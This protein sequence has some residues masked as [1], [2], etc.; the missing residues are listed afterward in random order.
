LTAAPS[1]EA[2]VR[3][4]D[5][6]AD[7]GV[8]SLKAYTD[9]RRDELSA[10]IGAAHRRGL[11]VTGHLCAVGFRQA[12]SVGIDNL[13][14]G[15]IVDTEFYSR[16]VADQCPGEA[17]VAEL[18]TMDV[19]SEPI[20]GTIRALV[21]RGV[22]ITSTLAIF[23]TFTGRST[24]TDPRIE[25]LL[26]WRDRFGYQKMAQ[27]RRATL[28]GQ[29]SAWD[30]ML[31][32][33]M[34]FERSFVSAGGLLMAGADPTGWG[35]LLAGFGDQRNV[36]LLV[37]AGFSPEQAIQIASANGA[38]FLGES[39]RIGTVE[40]GKQADLVVLR[41][42]LASDVNAIRSVEVVFKDGIGFN[43]ATLIEAEYGR[44]GPS[45]VK[46]FIIV[47]IVVGTFFVL[48]GRGYVRRRRQ[49]S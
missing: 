9:L 1:I 27:M 16:K 33:E 32:T 34:A 17:A 10:A 47:G 28:V 21:E 25:P 15:L 6:V 43:P 39:E 31:Q 2:L 29:F 3:V 7:A 5:T 13:E 35:G 19:N 18:A 22:A 37:E 44:V 40:R 30:Q 42:D 24:F 49:H 4:I 8:T 46:E 14:H 36:E 45:S 48:I 11:K 12:A 20:Q 23:E 26:N 41:G 38:K